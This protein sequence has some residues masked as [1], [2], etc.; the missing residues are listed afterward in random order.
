MSSND[1]TSRDRSPPDE[2]ALRARAAAHGQEHVFR[3]F[4]ELDQSGKAAFLEQLDRIDFD[5]MDRLLRECVVTPPAAPAGDLAPAPIVR[6][7]RTEEDRREEARARE[8]GEAL[9]REGKVA[10][11]L[12]AGGQ[13][14][15]L[16]FDGP[17]GAFVIG[18]VSRRTLFQLHAEKIRA[19]ARRHGMPIPWYVMTS[20]SNHQATIDELARHDFHGLDRGDIRFFQQEMLPAVDREGKFLLES[21]GRV[22]TSPNGH[23]GSLKALHD[24]GS[25]ADMRARGI[26]L[27]F[28]FQVDNPLVVMCDPVFIGRHALARAEISSKVVR[29][30]GWQ[31]KVGVIGLRGGKLTVIEY[32][33][34]PEAD[35]KATLSDGSL[36]YWAGSIAIH[37]LSA[38]FVERLNRGSFRLPYHIAEKAIPF[39]GE[40]GTV[41]KPGK[42]NGIKF[43][44]FVFDALEAAAGAVTMEVERREEFS[45]VKNATGDDS[46]ETARRDLTAL[47]LRWLEEAGASI[48]READGS[49]HGH[50]EV[51][52]LTALDGAELAKRVKP[53]TPVRPGFMV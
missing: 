33:D 32:S 15:R 25:L 43:E 51:S 12:V 5:L 8:A 20:E 6:I 45:P 23:G 37:V 30:A 44:T 2:G 1:R 18:P 19:L 22:F 38:G 50:V 53:G 42:K 41:V 52:P 4:D 10:A 49:F 24:S 13:G 21:K 28:Y 39:V 9:L 7:P 27:V 48:A 47:Y 31:E 17:K 16:G 3:F 11:L 46:P 35:A 14:S 40:D 26:E 34:L 29:K 36:E